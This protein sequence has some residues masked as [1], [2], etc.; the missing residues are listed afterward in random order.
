MSKSKNRFEI[1]RGVQ[2]P[3]DSKVTLVGAV[4]DE[5]I[6]EARGDSSAAECAWTGEAL[7]H[8]SPGR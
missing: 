1:A 7:R 5:I 6:G 2:Y 4:E 8:R 3:Y